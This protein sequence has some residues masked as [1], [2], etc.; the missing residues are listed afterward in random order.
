MKARQLVD[1]GGA[2]VLILRDVPDPVPGTG[3][4]LIRVDAA[5]I[6]CSDIIWRRGEYDVETPLPFIPSA[7]VAG[8][9]VAV[10]GRMRTDFGTHSCRGS[11]AIGR[12][13]AVRRRPPS[14]PHFQSL[15]GSARSK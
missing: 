15:T 1:T 6:N 8:T 5:G 14:R 9:V 12:L 11:A 13:C 4:V 2:E 10:G 7:E 3:E